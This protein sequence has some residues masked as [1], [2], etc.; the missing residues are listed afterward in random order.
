MCK[1]AVVQKK[2]KEK[3]VADFLKKKKKKKKET[4]HYRTAQLNIFGPWSA[5]CSILERKGICCMLPCESAHCS[6]W[7]CLMEGGV[8]T[9]CGMKHT[10]S[11]Y[12]KICQT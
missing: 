3:T 2:K 8:H 11:K 4:E 6:P 7:I 12:T 1:R 9:H 5:S 10:V